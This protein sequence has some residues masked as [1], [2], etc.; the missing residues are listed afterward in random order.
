VDY[1][2]ISIWQFGVIQ[3]AV[4]WCG[5]ALARGG[6]VGRHFDA[7]AVRRRARSVEWLVWVDCVTG[8]SGCCSI[9][10]RK[11]VYDNT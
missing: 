6:H 4:F 1:C 3:G 11:T 9:T 10:T 8:W 2:L 7:D 5:L